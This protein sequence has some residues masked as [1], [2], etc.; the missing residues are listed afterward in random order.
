MP[1]EQYKITNDQLH[2]RM[3]LAK[4]EAAAVKTTTAAD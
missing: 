3:K 2:R 4:N 1:T